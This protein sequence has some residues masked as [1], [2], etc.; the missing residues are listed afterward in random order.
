VPAGA[1][2]VHVD[3]CIH[4]FENLGRGSSRMMRGFSRMAA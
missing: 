3:P 1:P 2:A 4:G